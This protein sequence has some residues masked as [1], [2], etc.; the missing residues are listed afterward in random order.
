ML[1]NYS[2]AVFIVDP[3]RARAMVVSYDKL[4]DYKQGKEIPAEKKT[5][6]TLDAAIKKGDYVI[7]PTDT[8]WGFTVGRVEEENVR[9]NFG[10]AEVM[11]WIVGKV[12]KDGYD[13]LVEEEKNL[14][15][16]VAQAEE[17]AARNELAEKLK[18]LNPNLPALSYIQ[19]N[20]SG[21]TPVRDGGDEPQKR[22][23][24]Q[25]ETQF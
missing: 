1:T 7:V 6:K 25:P 13:K 3:Q 10:S 16:V 15:E 20:M 2:L 9:V 21:P 24:A 19:T 23:G 14:T 12:D 18:K 17:M 11:R 4:F 5:F 8:R 22:G